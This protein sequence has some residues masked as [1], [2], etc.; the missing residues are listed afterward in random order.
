MSW[1]TC[2]LDHLADALQKCAIVDVEAHLVFDPTLETIRPAVLDH[3]NAI[4]KYTGTDMFLLTSR[5]ADP[6]N[7]SANVISGPDQTLDQRLRFAIYGDTESSEHAKLRVLIM[8]DQTVRC[9]YCL[10]ASTLC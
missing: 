6:D 9:D 4:A 2:Q 7:L 5:P 3:I 10:A 1:C 8:I